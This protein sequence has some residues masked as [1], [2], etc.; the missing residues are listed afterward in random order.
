MN[1][2]PSILFASACL[3]P[4]H[5]M[6]ALQHNP[7]TID[8]KILPS[9][10][11]MRKWRVVY[12]DGTICRR[13]FGQY[14]ARQW[15]SEHGGKKWQYRICRDQSRNVLMREIIGD[16]LFKNWCVIGREKETGNRTIVARFRTYSGAQWW[17]FWKF[18]KDSWIMHIT[19]WEKASARIG[20]RKTA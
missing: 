7:I 17:A 18:D 9:F 15:K 20:H 4:D 14:A 3:T 5:E 6:S 2:K 16:F 12:I 13:F 1:E 11:K 10:W 8:P 19:E